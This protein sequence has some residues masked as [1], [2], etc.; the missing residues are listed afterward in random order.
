MLSQPRHL[1]NISRRLKLLLSD[2]D[3]LAA[4]NQQ[5][6]R[7]P[8]AENDGSTNA[9][10]ALPASLQEQLALALSRLVPALPQIPHILARL[11]TLAT[12]HASAAQFANSLS[13]LEEEERQSR[14][15]LD[16]L[17]QAIEGVEASISENGRVVK[18]NV[19]GLEERIDALTTRL[20]KLGGV[21]AT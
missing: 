1:D 19:T 20:D 5:S 14:E 8:T 11:R 7:G 9:P 15:A 4:A 21:P 13:A 12:L 16:A 2:L 3:R 10:A 6:R 18:G 17:T